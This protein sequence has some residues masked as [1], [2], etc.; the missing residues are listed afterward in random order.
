MLRGGT[1][2]DK[3]AALTLQV[4]ESPVHRLA[5]L[6]GLLDLG[7]KKERRTVRT[8]CIER[9]RAVSLR[10]TT[11]KSCVIVTAFDHEGS[12]A[13]CLS[14][15]RKQ[16]LKIVL[17]RVAIAVNGLAIPIGCLALRDMYSDGPDSRRRS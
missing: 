12:I 5:V 15:D 7:L 1:L 11:L 14:E 16:C 2:S 8:V 4:Q 10:Q 3:V 13:C 17:L 9:L 6:D